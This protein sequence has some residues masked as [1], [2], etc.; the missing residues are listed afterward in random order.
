[1]EFSPLWN[2]SC[3]KRVKIICEFPFKWTEN[4]KNNKKE[5]D[6]LAVKANSVLMQY[7]TTEPFI[8]ALE[9][10]CMPLISTA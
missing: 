8:S 9:N 10:I 7:I 2:K 3:F 6:W 5:T 4:G 1:M